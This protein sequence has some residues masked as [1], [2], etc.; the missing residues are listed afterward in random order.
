VSTLLRLFAEN[1][2]PVLIVAGVGFALQRALRFD[3]AP[4][5]RVAFYAALPA[6]QFDLLVS[7]DIL[8]AQLGQMMLLATVVIGCMAAIGFLVSRA[9]RLPERLAAAFI[10][11]VTF[12]NAGNYGL[13]VNKFAFG[14]PGLAWASVFFVTSSMLTNAAGVYVATVGRSSPLKAA[15]GL[16]KVPALYSIPLAL[17]VRGT[18]VVVPPFVA[19][20][21]EL[22]AAAA[23]P[24]MLL[25]LGMQMARAGKP[26]RPSLVGLIAGL[27]LVAS[28]VIAWMLVPAFSLPTL[29]GQVAV[30][31]AGMPSAV[32]NSIIATE[33]DAEPGFVAGAVLVSTLLSPLTLTPLVAWLG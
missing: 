17:L 7:S 30:L 14:E 32:L 8:P 19:R 1:L 33:F 29:A 20:P 11:S 2:L 27:R 15:A 26:Q 10:L 31:Q 22:L 16:L 4:L 28:P 25:L 18:G 6:L 21:I 9:L 13:S 5:S 3:P 24:I 23:V 12:M